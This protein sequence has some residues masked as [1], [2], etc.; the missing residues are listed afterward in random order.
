MLLTWKGL[1]EPEILKMALLSLKLGC[2][3]KKAAKI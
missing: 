1:L 2:E 3:H